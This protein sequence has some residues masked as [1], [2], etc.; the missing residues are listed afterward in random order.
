MGTQPRTVTVD[1]ADDR[2]ER[3]QRALD[4][5]LASSASLNIRGSSLGGF[6]AI[7]LLLAM[8][9][10]AIWLDDTK[11]R[12]TDLADAVLRFGLI[13]IGVGFA[14]CVILSLVAITPRGTWRG[15]QTSRVD[16][17]ARGSAAEEARV[18][19]GTL[20]K[21]RVRNDGKSR[22]LQ[23][24]SLAMAVALLAVVAQALAF[25][26][27]SDVRD[28]RL[29]AAGPLPGLAAIPLSVERQAEL[30]RQ[31]APV[32]YLHSKEQYKPMRV[33]TFLEGAALTWR[34]RRGRNDVVVKRGAIAAKRLGRGCD[35]GCYSVGGY[36]APELTRPYFERDRAAGLERKRGFALDLA[37]G[38]R[39]GEGPAA[40]M[41]YE[42]GVRKADDELRITYWF[43]YGYSVPYL[44]ATE[45]G[46]S[47][48][49]VAHEGD[50]E[51]VD[52]VLGLA[53]GAPRRVEFFGHGKPARVPWVNVERTG[54]GRTHPVVYSA[55]NSHASY[56]TDA[57]TKRADNTL[58]LGGGTRVCSVELRDRGTRWAPWEQGDDALLNAQA[59]PWYGFGGAWGRA[60]GI[61]DTTGPLGPSVYK[62]RNDR[63]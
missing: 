43:F 28:Q 14:G 16:L 55:R 36:L 13:A 39:R 25:T 32:V 37:D 7:A 33:A 47:I 4:Q 29:T 42:L 10:A 9:F 5:E 2:L 56:A 24:A 58:C 18:V 26:L 51:N 46:E 48:V 49:P 34:T 63:S 12:F 57:P 38:L 8:L 53:N 50:W 21:Q 60:S 62:L 35:Q 40:P 1:D 41:F 52:L 23:L 3:L 27:G 61:A 19:A 22:W 54:E 44:P 20:E 15:G 11:Y 31:Y 17:A 30:A 59:Q 45:G 6:A